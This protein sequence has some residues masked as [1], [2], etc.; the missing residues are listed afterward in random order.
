MS[1]IQIYIQEVS[2]LLQANPLNPDL[3]SN[4]Y[5]L[6]KFLKDPEFALGFLQQDGLPLLL[7]LLKNGHQTVKGLSL[8]CF[9]N[10]LC[11]YNVIS[12]I[13]G[14]ESLTSDLDV[15][16][17]LIDCFM[18]HETF[19]ERKLINESTCCLMFFIQTLQN[20]FNLFRRAMASFLEE[21]DPYQCLVDNVRH[22]SLYQETLRLIQL[23]IRNSI[24]INTSDPID[25]L[26][27]CGLVNQLK[28]LR[29]DASIVL[30][31]ADKI[32]IDEMLQPLGD[33][34]SRVGWYIDAIKRQPTKKIIEKVLTGMN[35]NMSKSDILKIA[36]E[37]LEDKLEEHLIEI[38]ENIEKEFSRMSSTLS[39]GSP[40]SSRS[41]SSPKNMGSPDS[42]SREACSSNPVTTTSTLQTI[43]ESEAYPCGHLC[44][45][46]KCCI[47][48]CIFFRTLNDYL[49]TLFTA[50]KVGG[51]A[52][53]KLDVIGKCIMLPGRSAKRNSVSLMSPFG[54]RTKR[55][56][57]EDQISFLIDVVSEST[58]QTLALR[59]YS[60]LYD[61]EDS[62]VQKLVECGLW[63]IMEGLRQNQSKSTYNAIL[64]SITTK[65]QDYIQSFLTNV[66][67]RPLDAEINIQH[68]RE[69]QLTA[70]LF[71]KRNYSL[72]NLG[73]NDISDMAIPSFLNSNGVETK[74]CSSN[75]DVP[76]P[77]TNK[78]ALKRIGEIDLKIIQTQRFI[79]KLNRTV[80][81][82][83]QTVSSLQEELTEIKSSLN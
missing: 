33:T 10:L 41:I 76:S 24:M 66:Y 49:K 15:F 19:G 31:E 3:G 21:K 67:G 29:T 73:E 58:S 9:L 14:Q 4:L 1:E 63:K 78:S 80:A 44:L 16:T 8:A 20:G 82:L 81:D 83:N 12:T 17:V 62:E 48:P 28:S 77:L 2:G 25:R 46:E 26:T 18:Q 39:L 11:H 34:C 13:I 45:N 47:S 32:L 35:A 30:S 55:E 71:F 51:G 60:A 23:I 65:P 50:L 74:V 75:P 40:S 43:T 5:P 72:D 27:K 38:H 52:P 6:T 56:K 54:R 61:L 22:S 57:K 7:D 69:G 36:D 59:Y 37:R 42:I 70:D 68:P 64:K 79:T 53:I